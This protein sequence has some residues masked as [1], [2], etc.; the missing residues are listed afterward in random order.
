FDGDAQQIATLHQF[1]G[2]LLHPGMEAQTALFLVGAAHTGKSVITDVLSYLLGEENVSSV[3]IEDMFSR[4]Q[5]WPTLGK[6]AN[7][8]NEISRLE[9]TDVGKFKSFT[10]GDPMQFEAKNLMS[11]MARPTAKI[12]VAANEMP[13]FTD[14][15]GGTWRRLIILRLDKVIPPSMRQS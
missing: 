11:F 5:L 4:F 2:Y 3:P 13:F 6:L 15:S 7:I 12:V 8:T 9:G 1:M 14:S 10:S